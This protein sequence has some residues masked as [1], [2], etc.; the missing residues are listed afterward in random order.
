MLR[1]NNHQRSLTDGWASFDPVD[2]GVIER[3]YKKQI[4][5]GEEALMLAVLD[6]AIECFQKYVL[7]KREREKKNVSRSRRVD[8]GKK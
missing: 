6:S 7:A 3:L 4:R 1:R 5:E 2:G 8:F